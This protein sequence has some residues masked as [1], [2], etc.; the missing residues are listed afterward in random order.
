MESRAGN[1]SL[2]RK[3]TS[4]DLKKSVMSLFCYLIIN[5]MNIYILS[6]FI[7]EDGKLLI[8]NRN[9]SLSLKHI[10]KQF[11]ILI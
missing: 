8:T 10:Q 2:F 4:Y 3:V 7:Y 9:V 1:F 11:G 5:E 6:S